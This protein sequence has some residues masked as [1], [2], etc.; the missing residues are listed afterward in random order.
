[1]IINKKL[2]IFFLE[3]GG[4]VGL[5]GDQCRSERRSFWENS[6]IK[7]VGVGGV[8]SGGGGGGRVGL[9]GTGWM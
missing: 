3:G 9:G 2:F 5:G 7:L 4:G 8:W 6:K 1:M